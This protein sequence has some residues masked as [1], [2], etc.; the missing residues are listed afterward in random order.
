MASAG[1]RGIPKKKVV[2]VFRSVY[3][4]TDIHPHKIDTE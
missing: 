2:K 3:F 4:E 1:Q